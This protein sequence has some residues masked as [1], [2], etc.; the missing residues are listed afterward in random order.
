MRTALLRGLVVGMAVGALAATFRGM[1][2]GWTKDVWQSAA[3]WGGV[4]FVSQ[5]VW[6]LVAARRGSPRKP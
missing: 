5:I 6:V 2:Y 1:K 4:Y 3:L